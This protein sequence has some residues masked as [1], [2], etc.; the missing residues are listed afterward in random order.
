[1]LKVYIIKIIFTAIIKIQIP[2]IKNQWLRQKDQM[3]N[4]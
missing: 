1:M 2:G 3:L 4:C